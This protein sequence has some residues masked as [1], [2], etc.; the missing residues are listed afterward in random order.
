MFHPMKK[1]NANLMLRSSIK[2]RGSADSLYYSLSASSISFDFLF[3]VLISSYDKKKL[4]GSLAIEERVFRA[5][6]EKG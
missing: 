2:S 6:Q 5:G 4:S 3:F 1:P